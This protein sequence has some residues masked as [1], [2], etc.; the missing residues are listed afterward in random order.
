MLTTILDYD[1]LKMPSFN[2]FLNCSGWGSQPYRLM[3]KWE[4]PSNI[5]LFT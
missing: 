2:G 3:L 1:A 4:I 5:V